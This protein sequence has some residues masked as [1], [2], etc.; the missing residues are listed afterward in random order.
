[1]TEKPRPNR[2][3]LLYVSCVVLAALA[4]AVIAWRLFPPM[5]SLQ[6][7]LLLVAVVLR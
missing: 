6:L 4:I 2:P 5:M 3:F 7:V 1:L